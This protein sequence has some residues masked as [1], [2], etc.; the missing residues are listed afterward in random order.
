[1]KNVITFALLTAILLAGFSAC[2]KSSGTTYFVKTTINGMP[3]SASNCVASLVSD[4][5]LGISCGNAN[6]YPHIFLY[7]S[8]YTGAGTYPLSSSLN[9]N[10]GSV[11]SSLS[12]MSV[13]S[14]SGTITITKTSPA[15]TGT[16]SFIG[17][18]SIVVSNG[19]FTAQ[20]P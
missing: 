5:V 6:V 18:D 19:K 16:F 14:A 2:H 3:Y 8:D 13:T 12:V 7:I 20:L 9:G 4:T 11:D 1:M 10:F 15:I 17:T